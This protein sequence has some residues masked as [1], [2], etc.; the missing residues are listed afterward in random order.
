MGSYSGSRLFTTHL[1]YGP[2]VTCSSSAQVYFGNT[3]GH[4]ESLQSLL[5]TWYKP[6]STPPAASSKQHQQPAKREKRYLL[7]I[8]WDRREP[9]NQHSVLLYTAQRGSCLHVHETLPGTTSRDRQ[10]QRFA[11]SSLLTAALISRFQKH[12]T[13]LISSFHLLPV[14][15]L[16]LFRRTGGR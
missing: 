8:G 14:F 13:P 12:R 10:E 6:Q 9:L 1:S 3:G 11:G 16:G 2:S 15:S 7:G 5:W 4:A